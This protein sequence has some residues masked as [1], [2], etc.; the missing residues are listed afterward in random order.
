MQMD[1]TLQD[2]VHIPL[3]SPATAGWIH[4]R[5]GMARQQ[6]HSVPRARP[7]AHH[8]S[9]HC[10]GDE[11]D[12]KPKAQRVCL[13]RRV[14]LD[15]QSGEWLYYRRANV[16]LPPVLFERRYG[17]QLAFRHVTGSGT[18]EFL[19]L[20]KHVRYKP[21]VRWSPIVVDGGA[22]T[23]RR[24]VVWASRGALE[25]LA[26]H[27]LKATPCARDRTRGCTCC[28]RPSCRP[29][30]ATS[31]GRRPSRCCSPW[32]SWACAFVENKAH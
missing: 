26:C 13:F 8:S 11:S 14:C 29:T 27:T 3:A 17:S 25:P 12:I 6:L 1:L 2:T 24:D 5:G 23:A 20:N 7:E 4:G 28:Q 10:V 21:H 15:T 16:S 30:L 22:P 18:E 9:H 32:P 31:Y 19:A